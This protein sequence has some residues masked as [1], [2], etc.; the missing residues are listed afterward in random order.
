MLRHQCTHSEKKPIDNGKYF[1]AFVSICYKKSKNV[2]DVATLKIVFSVFSVTNSCINDCDKLH[3]ILLLTE[4]IF[5]VKNV[6]AN[7][8][9]RVIMIYF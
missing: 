1:I 5:P 2:N 7:R 6:S 3:V 4:H 8:E 9:V